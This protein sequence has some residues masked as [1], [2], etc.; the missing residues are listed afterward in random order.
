VNL[1]ISILSWKTHLNLLKHAESSFTQFS[2][3]F[4]SLLPIS[5]RLT[6]LEFHSKPRF[7][8]EPLY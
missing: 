5:E 8:R 1:N 2:S 3:G 7:G 6:P 4:A